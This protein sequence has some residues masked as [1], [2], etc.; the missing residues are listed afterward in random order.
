MTQK[1]LALIDGSI[2]SHSVCEHAAWAA[3]RLAAPVELLH[4][5]TR[6]RPQGRTCLGAIQL[7]ARSSLL[8]E[9]AAVD[10]Q[11]SKLMAQQG[12]AILEDAQAVVEKAGVAAVTTR[13]R[14]GDLVETMAAQEADAALIVIG[15]R[16]EHADFAVGHLGSNLERVVRA[17][18]KPV[19]IAARAFRPIGR[20]LLAFDGGASALRAVRMMADSPLFAGLAVDIVSV[21]QGGAAVE[22]ALADAA[23]VLAGAG[24]QVQTKVIAG[25]P[26]QVLA[27][28]VETTPFDLVVMGTYGHSR[29]RSLIIGSTTTEMIRSCKVPLLVVR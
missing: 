15:K 10:E 24:L 11:R 26:E 28:L 13:L 12:R 25:Q 18:H 9:L 29:I 21:G 22:T 5:L 8:Q 20:V 6:R 16:G 2:Y 23:Q 14:H 4:L 1:V 3:G 17:S 7:G 19:L 27:G